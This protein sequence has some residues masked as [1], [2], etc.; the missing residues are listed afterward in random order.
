MAAAILKLSRRLAQL[1]VA[2]V[3]LGALGAMARQPIPTPNSAIEPP[4]GAFGA[5]P[6]PP[7]RPRASWALPEPIVG[8]PVFLGGSRIAVTVSRPDGQPEILFLDHTGQ[9][10]D[11][12]PGWSI[13]AADG[14]QLLGLSEDGENVS[15]IDTAGHANWSAH[16]P[17]GQPFL[18][19]WL[20]GKQA[21]LLLADGLVLDGPGGYRWIIHRPRP[22]VQPGPGG[23]A[24]LGVG[25][26]I[27]MMAPNG[28]FGY[29]WKVGSLPAEWRAADSPTNGNLA[30]LN[31]LQHQ[32]TLYSANGRKLWTVP[33][34]GTDLTFASDGRILVWSHQLVEAWGADGTPVGRVEGAELW[35]N[36]AGPEPLALVNGTTIP[37]RPSYLALE[38]LSGSTLW[39][40]SVHGQVSGMWLSP[41][42]SYLLVAVGQSGL[43]SLK[44][45]PLTAQ[46]AAGSSW[47]LWRKEDLAGLAA[48]HASESGPQ[49][50]VVPRRTGTGNQTAAAVLLGERVRVLRSWGQPLTQAVTVG[51]GIMAVVSSQAPA[52]VDLLSDRGQP[53]GS[54]TFSGQRIAAVVAQGGVVGVLLGGQSTGPATVVV[55]G[56]GGLWWQRPVPAA[57]GSSPTLVGIETSGRAVIRSG[58]H[59]FSLSPAGLQPL[60]L[61]TIVAVGGDGVAAVGPDHI[62]RYYVRDRLRWS[63]PVA[64]GTF[65]LRF[66][67]QGWYLLLVT[68]RVLPD[69]GTGRTILDRAELFNSAGH[70]LWQRSVS[71]AVGA[72]SVGPG[73]LVALASIPDI[74]AA[75]QANSGLAPTGVDII[76]AHG[77]IVRHLE[78]PSGIAALAVGDQGHLLF[79]SD[80]LYRLEVWAT[81]R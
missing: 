17:T 20:A 33:S 37:N 21:Y 28:Q 16:S 74:Q 15:S 36:A 50:L 73:G 67:P 52:T 58:Q 25:H 19:G 10:V 76:D 26:Q 40:E 65:Q 69:L 35:L 56:R 61:A 32:L 78:D 62:L 30:L 77:R 4:Q 44:L 47:L 66:S 7:D 51:N 72:V 9:V 41:D 34:F 22:T 45:P 5:S 46:P 70:L 49:V 18:G 23:V 31:P 59:L 54:Y 63:R 6:L 11:R 55:L 71:L 64:G 39:R 12:E 60:G 48:V 2:G 42:H 27:V 79:I 24:L 75:A 53:A 80:Y 43:E 1:A 38:D 14:T 81:G 57:A 8:K 29:A 3:I 68:R 13:L